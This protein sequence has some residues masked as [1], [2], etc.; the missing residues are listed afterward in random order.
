MMKLII[1]FLLA[2]VL[3]G[4]SHSMPSN[5]T[6]YIQEN[7]LVQ[8]TQNTPLPDGLTGQDVYKTLNDWQMIYQ[9]CAVSKDAL[10]KA[11][12]STNDSN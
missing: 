1:V 8:C 11:V 5:N 2:L 4:C 9:E 3:A 6:K 12:R 7:L 10:I